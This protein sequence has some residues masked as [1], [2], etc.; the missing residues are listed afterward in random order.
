ME[1]LLTKLNDLWV[2][3]GLKVIYVIVILFI[4]SKLIKL[5]I[6]LIKKAKGFNKLDKSVASF[7]LSFLKATG[8]VKFK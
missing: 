7:L 1:K 4:G 5:L 8:S 2:D 6:K 3:A